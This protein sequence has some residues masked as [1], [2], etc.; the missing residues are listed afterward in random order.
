MLKKLKYYHYLLGIGI[1][2]V[3]LYSGIF[4]IPLMAATNIPCDTSDD[5][6][7]ACLGTTDECVDGFCDISEWCIN[8]EDTKDELKTWFKDNIFVWIQNNFLLFAGFC[9]LAIF[10]IYAYVAKK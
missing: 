10:I 8:Q 4:T 2:I 7:N 9:S 1:V 5:C 6:P 3:L